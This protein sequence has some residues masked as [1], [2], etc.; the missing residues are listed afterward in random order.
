MKSVSKLSFAA[1]VIIAVV[2]A[3]WLLAD[4]AQN[5]PASDGAPDRTAEIKAGNVDISE[6]G[7]KRIG[8]VI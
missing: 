7:Q 5:Q 6:A 2:I 8:S 4:S 1:P 3:L